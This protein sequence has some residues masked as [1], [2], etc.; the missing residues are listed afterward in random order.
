VQTHDFRLI[1]KPTKAR[2]IK[3][4]GKNKAICPD[5]H[6][7]AGNKCWVFADEVVIR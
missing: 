5:W 6:K 4:V 2:Y 3:V 1:F 7:G